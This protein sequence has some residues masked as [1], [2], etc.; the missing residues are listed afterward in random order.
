[1]EISILIIFCSDCCHLDRPD[2][3]CRIL[4]TEQ[5]QF[6]PRARLYQT[7]VDPDHGFFINKGKLPCFLHLKI[8][9]ICYLTTRCPDRYGVCRRHGSPELCHKSFFPGIYPYF[10]IFGRLLH[11]C[12][13]IP[14]KM[15]GA[16]SLITAA[17]HHRPAPSG[18]HTVQ[19]LCKQ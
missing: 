18:C 14:D 9:W 2:S 5:Y 19:I 8:H 15:R 11:A 4:K 6:T 13:S 10:H 17:H 1:M 12:R 7:M 16:V 3:R